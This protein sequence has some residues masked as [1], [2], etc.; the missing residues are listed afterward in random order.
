MEQDT[1]FI[2]LLALNI[3]NKTFCR[4]PNTACCVH[5]S[6]SAPNEFHPTLPYH[7][8]PTLLACQNAIWLLDASHVVVWNFIQSNGLL[9]HDKGVFEL[10]IDKPPS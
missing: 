3:S 6:Y 5:S 2:F 1:F 7:Q 10:P 8:P 9:L 4:W